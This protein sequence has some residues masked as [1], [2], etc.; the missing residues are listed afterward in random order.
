MPSRI[1]V[2][3]TVPAA[4]RPS[5]QPRLAGCAAVAI[6]PVSP[7]PPPSL[8]RCLPSCCR[9]CVLRV[10]APRLCAVH[11][12]ADAHAVTHSTT[13]DA[14]HNDHP[15]LDDAAR[16]QQGAVAQLS[17]AAAALTASA[18]HDGCSLRR[19]HRAVACAATSRGM[20]LSDAVVLHSVR[21]SPVACFRARDRHGARIRADKAS[22]DH[23]ERTAKPGRGRCSP[24]VRTRPPLTL[25]SFALADDR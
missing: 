24:L 2:C 17:S 3:P 15:S 14:A 16:D 25:F 10:V 21:W 11:R 22:T 7:A 18:Q 5:A 8:C 19:Q 13:S 23:S 12:C 9:R 20:H 6:A 4:L 1:A